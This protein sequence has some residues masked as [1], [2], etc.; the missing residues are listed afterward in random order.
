MKVENKKCDFHHRVK[1]YFKKQPCTFLQRNEYSPYN[2]N[3]RYRLTYVLLSIIQRECDM[4]CCGHTDSFKH[5]LCC[6]LLVTK[7]KFIEE[8]TRSV[9]TLFRM[10]AGGGGGGQ[11]GPPPPILVFSL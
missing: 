8:A 11:K 7:S 2:I 3:Q 10:G 9:L 6:N 5:N 1:K 4:S